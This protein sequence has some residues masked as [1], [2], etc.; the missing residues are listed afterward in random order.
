MPTWC[1]RL[2]GGNVG[3]G[4][5]SRKFPQL[6]LQVTH[7]MVC[8]A[9]LKDLS[10]PLPGIG[11]PPFYELIM[12][13]GTIG[14]YYSRARDSILVVILI[15]S[16]AT[17]PYS[18]AV[19]LD[20]INEG[21]DARVDAIIHKL[22]VS[23]ANLGIAGEDFVARVALA[24]GDG[25]YASGGP[26]AANKGRKVMDRPEFWGFQPPLESSGEPGQYRVVWDFSIA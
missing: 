12:D 5:H 16:C 21:D 1:D 19:I 22:K 8:G 3:K 18:K 4:N 9:E 20:L 11:I 10:E 14:K 13:G 25:V 7:D 6:V 26:D 17:P 15:V 2:G 23:V 24:C